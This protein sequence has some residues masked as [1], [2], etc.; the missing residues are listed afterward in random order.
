MISIPKTI[1]LS[2][3]RLHGARLDARSLD[4]QREFN[5]SETAHVSKLPQ[6]GARSGAHSGTDE[7]MR[8]IK[9]KQRV[10]TLRLPD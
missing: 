6:K 2:G 7:G 8:L 1:A 9:P 5:N 4:A 3:V 10:G